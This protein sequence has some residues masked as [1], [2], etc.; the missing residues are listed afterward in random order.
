[1][2]PAGCSNT[3]IP[4]TFNTNCNLLLTQLTCAHSSHAAAHQWALL[5]AQI[6]PYLQ[7]STQTLICSSHNQHVPTPHLQLYINGPCWVLKYNHTFNLQHKLQSAPHTTNMCP[8]LTC[9]CTSMGPA[10]CSNTTIP[11]TFNTNYNLLLTQLTCA[12]VLTCSCTSMGPAGCSNT[13]IPST[14]NTNYNLLLTQPTYAHV[15]TCSCTSMALLGAQIQPYLQPSTQTTICSSHNQRV[16]NPHLQLHINGPSWVQNTTIPSTFNTNYN[17]LLTQPTCAQSS[18]AAVHQWAL[19]GAQI[20]PYLQPLTQTAIC[21][22]HNQHVPTSSPAAAHQWALL[23][24]QMQPYLQPSTQTTICSSH[25]QHVPT[26][27]LQLHINGPSWVLKYNHTFNLQHKLQSAPH[28][29]NVCPRPH[30]QLHINGP[31]WVL[32]YNHTSNL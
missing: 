19:L 31:C 9:S 32:K 21:S 18:P 4:P 15:L 29:T 1:M 17:L 8:L 28:T 6:Q 30:L 5:G 20:Q 13:T 3:T 7:P 10:G 26:P 25:N 14:F 24:A 2:G 12:H 16:P 22:S 27:H 11:S 23:G